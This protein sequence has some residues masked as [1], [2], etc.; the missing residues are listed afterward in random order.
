MPQPDWAG[1][2]R[3]L[4]RQLQQMDRQAGSFGGGVAGEPTESSARRRPTPRATSFNSWIVHDKDNEQRNLLTP[5]A[6]SGTLAVVVN[7]AEGV[8]PVRIDPTFSD[9]NWVSMGGFPGANVLVFATVTDGSGNFY[10][11]AANCI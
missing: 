5:A 6:T 3:P 4:E 11:T 8:Y 1:R 9:A 10:I 2:L 7:D